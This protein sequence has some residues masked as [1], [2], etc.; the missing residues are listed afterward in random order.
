MQQ[1]TGLSGEGGRKIRNSR[2]DIPIVY[3]VF[4]ILYV[5]G[6]SLFRVNL[7]ERKEL[8]RELLKPTDLVR[9]SEH[10]DDGTALYKAAAERELEGIIAKRKKSCYIEK[11][12]SEWLKIKITQV[13]ECVIGGYTDPKGTRPNFG[14]IVLGLYDD[15]KRLISVGQAGSGFTERTHAEMWTKLKKLET[16]K[17]PFATKVESSRRTHWVKPELVAQ[18]KF[19]EWTHEGQSGAVKMRAPVF[20]GLR[21]DK[22]PEECRFEQV[23]SAKE[24]VAKAES[25]EAA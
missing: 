23:K 16:T 3:Y 9:Y 6:Y 17:N 11:R 1:R 24:E 5:D 10:F 14:S 12:S 7:E 13:V 21:T 20:L 2:P 19:S 18:I 15:R 25:G 8:L 22:K 4:D